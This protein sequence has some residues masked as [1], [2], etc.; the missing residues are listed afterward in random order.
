VNSLRMKV[1]GFDVIK[2][3]LEIKFASDLA[4][5]PIDEYETH[6]F[7]VVQE[8]N[9]SNEEILKALAQNGW[10]IALQQEIAEQLAKDNEKVAQYKSYVGKELTYTTEELFNPRP[11]IP[12]EDQPLSEG[13]MVI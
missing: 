8:G 10:N 7:N 12:A 13:L 6:L 3:T 1:V 11:T 4:E 2:S 9:V 5:K